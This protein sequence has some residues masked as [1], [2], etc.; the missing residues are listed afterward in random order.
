MKVFISWSGTRSEYIANEL[1]A[2]LPNL[3]QA[4]QPFVSTRDIMK[5]DRGLNVIAKELE[6][7]NIGLICLTPEN[8]KSEWILFEAGALSKSSASYVCTFLYDVLSTNVRAPLGEFQYTKNERED[9]KQL[10]ATINELLPLDRRLDDRRFESA[11]STWY[12]Q[13]EEKLKSVPKAKH[14]ETPVD[15]R[16]P[17]D[18]L[19]EVLRAI[20]NLPGQTRPLMPDI[21]ADIELF[22]PTGHKPDVP[23]FVKWVAG[24][25]SLGLITEERCKHM[26][27]F[28]QALKKRLV[29]IVV[30]E[31]GER[32]VKLTDNGVEYFLRLFPA[33]TL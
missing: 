30:G 28:K 7:T 27:Y 5:G 13:L 3:L 10:C 24:D 15:A 21:Y 12:P 20:R 19:D 14:D 29:R 26:D 2:W 25:R 16:T 8:L 22:P 32:I 1:R 9:I 6:Q 17:E 4:I 31:R 18:K 11:F 23:G 33:E